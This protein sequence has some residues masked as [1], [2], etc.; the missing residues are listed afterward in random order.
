M[1]DAVEGG[2]NLPTSGKIIQQGTAQVVCRK[3]GHR[4][5]IGQLVGSCPLLHVRVAVEDLPG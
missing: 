5:R 4:R 2:V 3:K 1:R